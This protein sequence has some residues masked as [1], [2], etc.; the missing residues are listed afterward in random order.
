MGQLESPFQRQRTQSNQKRVSRW[1]NITKYKIHNTRSKLRY[2]SVRQHDDHRAHGWQCP[3]Y[4]K[5]FIVKKGTLATTRDMWGR[6]QNS[7]GTGRSV[8]VV[9]SG[10]RQPKTKFRF[11]KASRLA[12]HDWSWDN[13]YGTE[14]LVLNTEMGDSC[15]PKSGGGGGTAT[16]WNR[17][18]AATYTR[19][20]PA[21]ILCYRG[22]AVE[23]DSNY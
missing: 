22:T 8:A 4:L 11:E 5:H 15:T 2:V 14:N 10:Y 21:C 12:N 13:E 16:V 17:A 23:F 19:N 7:A 1:K 6:V 20:T 18:L 3:E 9:L